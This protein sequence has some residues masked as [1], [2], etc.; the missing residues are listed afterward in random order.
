MHFLDLQGM[1]KDTRLPDSGPVC[2]YISFTKLKPDGIRQSLT[3]RH[4]ARV[5]ERELYEVCDANGDICEA[6]IAHTDFPEASACHKRV[7][8]EATTRLLFVVAVAYCITVLNLAPEQILYPAGMYGPRCEHRARQGYLRPLCDEE[9]A[10]R[11]EYATKMDE[12]IL[13]EVSNV[14]CGI[15]CVNAD[16]MNDILD[17]ARMIVDSN[18]IRDFSG[19]TRDLDIVIG[20]KTLA[21]LK[22]FMHP[23][24]DI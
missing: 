21:L 7:K 11:S 15:Y 3:D 6:Y 13:R 5:A 12:Y 1:S 4:G 10:C 24:A 20:P 22:S 18:Q 9:L 17:D 16:R 2:R 23:K 19:R 8:N 14:Q